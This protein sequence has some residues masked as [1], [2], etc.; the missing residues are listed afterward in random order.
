MFRF[1]IPS[2]LILAWAFY[3]LSGGAEFE[4]VKVRRSVDLIPAAPSR[5]EPKP[6]P[7]VAF[8]EATPAAPVKV[9]A[10]KPKPEPKPTAEV[11]SLASVETVETETPVTRLST[12]DPTG[13]VLKGLTTTGLSALGIG[14]TSTNDTAVVET[15]VEEVTVAEVDPDIRKIA[16]T[17]VNM[18]G[19]P[20]TSYS[21]VAKLERGEEVRVVGEPQPG[22]L[23]LRTVEGDRLGYVAAS[24]VTPPN[25]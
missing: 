17:R 24:L 9:A 6:R 12:L 23:M 10:P 25:S 18:R 11:F 15:S 16:A 8:A 19:G 1:L 4:P 14:T 2:F 5:P 13:T 21:V 3:E 7:Q 20:G 22:W